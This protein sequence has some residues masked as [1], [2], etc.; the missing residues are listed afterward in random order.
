MELEQEF[1][2]Q[3]QDEFD[4]NTPIGNDEK[5]RKDSFY[6][7]KYYLK[8]NILQ[9]VIIFERLFS[10]FISFHFHIENI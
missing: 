6:E 5:T 10:F 1:D 2:I 4:I 9:T 3:T 7:W 8:I